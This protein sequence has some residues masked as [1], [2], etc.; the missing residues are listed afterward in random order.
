MRNEDDVQPLVVDVKEAA[1]LLG[2]YRQKIND[3]INKGALH[4]V[5]IGGVKRIPRSEI[6]RV[7]R[8]GDG[9]TSGRAEHM[10]K[11]REMKEQA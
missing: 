3:M 1:R 9:S 6:M 8:D 11:A 10:L 7:I 5:M 4:C 2:T